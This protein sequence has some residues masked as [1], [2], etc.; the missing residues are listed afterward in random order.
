[1]IMPA[2][3][4]PMV[5]VGE[6]SPL[7]EAARPT[8]ANPKSSLALMYLGN[9]YYTFGLGHAGFWRAYLSTR[10]LASRY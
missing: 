8:A 1:M 2:S 7:P 9:R 3:V 4:I 5:N 6:F 10:R